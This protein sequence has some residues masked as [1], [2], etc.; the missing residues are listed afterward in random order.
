ME[1]ELRSGLNAMLPRGMLLSLINHTAVRFDVSVTDID[2]FSCRDCPAFIF[3][4]SKILAPM[5]TRAAAGDNTD[6]VTLD[7]AC[8]APE[9]SET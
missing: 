1:M 6:N 2:P 9:E 4:P 7:C 3:F 8:L 5:C